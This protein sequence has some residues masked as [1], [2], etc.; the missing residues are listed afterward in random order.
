MVRRAR[1][2]WGQG[3]GFLGQCAILD[4]EPEGQGTVGGSFP[5]FHCLFVGEPRISF[6]GPQKPYPPSSGP[7][8]T[9]V[10]AVFICFW[11]RFHHGFQ[12][13]VVEQ[14]LNK[15]RGTPCIA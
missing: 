11:C 10:L 12:K 5:V 4:L 9:T 6:S 3:L 15:S 1:W 7:S 13:S 2:Y 14:P 8:K